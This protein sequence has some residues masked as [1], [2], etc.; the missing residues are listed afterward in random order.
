[1]PLDR[2]VNGAA[3]I[4]AEPD[5]RVHVSEYATIRFE[6]HGPIG[7]ITLDRPAELNPL[8]DRTVAELHGCLDALDADGEVELLVLR[9]EG[10]AFSAGGDLK[11]ALRL[12]TDS[13]WMAA[14]ADNL[15]RLLER[16]ERSDK[17]VIAVVSGLCVAGGIE[18]ILACDFVV[19]ADDARFPDGHLNFS[20]LPG[21]GGTQR[22]PRA[23][24]VLR[25]KD[26]LLT[27]RF[28]DG[29]EAAQIG[30][31]SFSVPATDLERRVDELTTTLLQK[32]FSSRR[33]IK[34]LANQGLKGTLSEGLHLE[35]AYVLHYETT[36]PDAH[37]GLLAFAEKRRPR[38]LSRHDATRLPD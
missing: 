28:F 27:A 12:H 2:A 3:G 17:I 19:A 1:V 15:R 23:I 11:K 30:L 38:F 32:S 35:A 36:H 21:A 34:Y 4:H 5:P 9:G 7:T 26:L 16:L 13:R 33:A 22:M 14:L 37:E 31:V 20:L 8:D 29:R 24:G 10:R 25:A 18:L 6:K